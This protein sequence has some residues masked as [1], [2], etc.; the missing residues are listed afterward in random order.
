MTIEERVRFILENPG[1][2]SAEIAR[3]IKRSRQAVSMIRDGRMC[4]DVL[5]ELPRQ[6][7]NLSSRRCWHCQ[8]SSRSHFHNWWREVEQRPWCS[9]DIP[10]SIDPVFARECP[11][12]QPSKP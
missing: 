4:V 12:F 2:S 6:E 9:I 10:E 7:H 8:L 3:R 11:S 1:L 5:P